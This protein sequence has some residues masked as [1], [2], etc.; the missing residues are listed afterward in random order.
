WGDRRDIRAQ[1]GVVD[2]QIRW[3]QLQA[4]HAVG[5]AWAADLDAYR[6][7]ARQLTGAQQPLQYRA[8]GFFAVAGRQ[9]QDAD[10]V[11]VGLLGAAAEQRIVGAP[12]LEG[13]EQRIPEHVVAERARLFDQGM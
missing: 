8:H 13:R 7:I 10:V 6:L 5:R 1:Q 4:R 12:I 3:R 11:E 2:R 9:M